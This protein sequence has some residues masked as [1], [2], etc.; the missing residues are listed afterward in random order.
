MEALSDGL[1][2]AITAAPGKVLYVADYAAIEA[3]VLLWLAGAEHALDVFRR[4][5]DIYCTMA[6]GIYGR[7]I[8]KADKDERQVGK[9]AILGL[10]Y[11]MGASKFVDT[12][13]AMAG[14][15]IEEDFAQQV[16]QTYRTQFAEVKQL[17]WDT[18]SAAIDAVRSGHAEIWD[19]EPPFLFCRLPSG[20]RLAYPFPEIKA[21]ATP[22]GDVKAS[23]TFMG[24]NAYS[25]QW[26]RQHTYG[27]SLVENIVQAISR[28]ILAEAML[29]CE[30]TGLYHPVLSVHDELI[31]EAPEG[32]GSVEE[33][34]TL[35]E[36]PPEWAPDCPIKAEGF[37]TFR[38]H[39]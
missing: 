37:S 28:D 1:R 39:K 17:W 15:T 32:Q 19:Y 6:S 21:R 20:R 12:C 23:L 29:R 24:T 31:C 5:E 16:V 4:G 11:G 10:G 35:L 30:W 14:V 33:F 34:V 25:R 22:W 3:R 26:A 18:E 38:Y 7:P 36:E 2:G 9:T 13:A 8:T 27:G